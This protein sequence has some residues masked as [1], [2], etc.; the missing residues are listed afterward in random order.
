[1]FTISSEAL[2]ID[3]LKESLRDPG[4]GCS[5]T[6]EGWVRNSHEGRRVARL[7]YEVYGELAERE[8]GKILIEAVD[9]FHLSAARCVHRT[10]TLEIGEAAVWIGVSA[11]HRPDA[12]AACR[13]I[14]DEI[15]QRVPI[16]KKEEYL[17]GDSAWVEG[18]SER[19]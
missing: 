17:D 15:K 2:D 7:H 11:P 9:Q 5:V 4:A 19:S 16:W 10:G 12:F 13:Y 6:F 18:E 8:G 14:I 1:M 3:A